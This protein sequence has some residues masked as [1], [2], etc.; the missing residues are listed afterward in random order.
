VIEWLSQWISRLA[1]KDPKFWSLRSIT[2]SLNR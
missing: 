2:Q 1:T